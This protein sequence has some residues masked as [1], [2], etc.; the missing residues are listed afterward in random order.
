MPYSIKKS[1]DKYKVVKKEGGKVMGTHDTRQ[2]AEK[3]VR[4]LYAEEG[5]MSRQG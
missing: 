2:K 1:N 4:A 3:Q 5:K